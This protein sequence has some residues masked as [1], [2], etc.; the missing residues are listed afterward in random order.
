MNKKG[1]NSLRDLYRKPLKLNN[2]LK[3]ENGYEK[4]QILHSSQPNTKQKNR[5][6][7]HLENH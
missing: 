6:K 1:T 7:G 4:N 2:S 3:I 5:T